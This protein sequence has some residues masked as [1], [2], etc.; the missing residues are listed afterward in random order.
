MA[1]RVQCPQCGAANDGARRKCRSCGARLAEQLPPPL[2]PPAVSPPAPPQAAQPAAESQAAEP[3]EALTE[4][5]PDQQRALVL[6]R[7]NEGAANATII[8]ELV[9][10]GLERD[11]ATQLVEAID[12]EVARAA[13][14]EQYGLGNLL[15]GLIG[16][17]L[18]AVIAG[19]IWGLVVAKTQRELAIAALGVGLLVGM[20]VVLLSGGKKGRPFQ[21][22]A[23]L[24]SLFGILM[25]K[26]AAFF[27]SLKDYIAE[28]LGAEVAGEMSLFSPESI[29][30][31]LTNLPEL[32]R[33][34]ELFSVYDILWVILAVISAWRI[35]KALG[36]K[37]PP[38]L[39]P[40]PAPT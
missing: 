32:V 6:A 35:P 19:V 27:F 15:G 31:F 10:A 13:S 16:A 4:E 18:A 39:A 14:A 24:G 26:Y 17:L 7:M 29:R 37:R 3:G 21:I 40:P 28:Q 20:A 1:G 25:G 11:A 38:H 12:Q 5:A 9:R 2:P 36:V 23:V 22:I 30:V 8:A 33:E 34:G